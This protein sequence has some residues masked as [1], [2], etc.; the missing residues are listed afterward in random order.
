MRP[1]VKIGFFARKVKCHSYLHI[2]YFTCGP[3]ILKKSQFLALSR[4]H[5]CL[6]RAVISLIIQSHY[7]NATCCLF[8]VLYV[9]A[10]RFL[11]LVFVCTLLIPTAFVL[12]FNLISALRRLCVFFVCFF[13]V[14]HCL[15]V[16]WLSSAT[17]CLC[18]V[19]FFRATRCLFAYLVVCLVSESL[20]CCLF[21]C[22]VLRPV[23]VLLLVCLM[24]RAVSCL[25]GTKRCLCV[26]VC[27]SGVTRFL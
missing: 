8:C 16:V 11:S 17:R 12:F 24:L 3:I 23:F 20:C 22:L 10:M 25:F 15:C 2:Y 5:Q 14:T 21:V 4:K 9:N 26:L 19:C 18:V 6:K 27:L 7:V 13:S 1:Q